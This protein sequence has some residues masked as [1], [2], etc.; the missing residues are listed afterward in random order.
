MSTKM[1]RDGEAE[2]DRNAERQREMQPH[3]GI[4]QSE[5]RVV[6]GKEAE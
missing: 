2:R 6:R 1:Q 5:R 3:L 4:M